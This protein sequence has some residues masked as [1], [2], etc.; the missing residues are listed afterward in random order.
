MEWTRHHMAT[1]HRETSHVRNGP[2]R[3]LWG[4]PYNVKSA[5]ARYSRMV[6]R[7]LVAD[8]HTVEILRLEDKT[9]LDHDILDH[10]LPVHPPYTF[11]FARL[12]HDYD[13]CVINYG[14]YFPFHAG[15][16]DLAA[17]TPAV[18]V[19]HDA[20]LEG[21]LGGA[22]QIHPKLDALLNRWPPP[23]LTLPEK[24][25]LPKQDLS[26]FAALA[27]GCVVHGSHYV[28]D[29]VA[30]C[31]GP[32]VQMPLCYPDVGAV[33]PAPDGSGAFIVTCFG[34]INPNKQPERILRAL[35]VDPKL[36]THGRMHFVGAIDEGYRTRL[37]ALAADLGLAAPEFT[38]W[39][40]DA[41]LC[42]SL[43]QAHLV[44]CLR[45]P[46]TEGH[47]ASIITALYAARPIVVNDV[48]S[49]AEIPD[50]LV[51][52][53]EAG[54]APAPLAA[55]MAEIARDPQA[56]EAAAAGAAA[57]ARVRY[58]AASYV[59]GLIP[60]LEAAITCRPGLEAG[61]GMARHLTNLGVT[62]DDSATGLP[63][64]FLACAG[65]PLMP[66]MSE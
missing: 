28:D 32:T 49:Y 23:G 30:T 1:H 43:A 19:F 25:T 9:A 60:L 48:G 64:K 16:L 45:H 21:F 33:P 20:N 18:A 53:I 56:A 22:R 65:R 58:S 29:V 27:S 2:M 50:G 44:C 6:T 39:V 3:I 37:A 26:F 10:N 59:G 51:H 66:P 36:R 31:P 46:M 62:F 42:A 11:D 24:C 8:G 13:V 38:G 40:D 55:V 47:S 17:A 35:A 61:R 15:A 4:T 63:R 52:K 54:D 14:D 12:R 41:H 7:A 34:M 57:W 5:I